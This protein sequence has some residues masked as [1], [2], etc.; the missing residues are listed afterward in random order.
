[1]ARSPAIGDNREPTDDRV[2]NTT[3]DVAEA[4]HDFEAGS[5]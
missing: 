3:R 4:R 2:N 5:L 1:M